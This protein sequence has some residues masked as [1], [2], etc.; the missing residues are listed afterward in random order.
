ML[1]KLCHGESVELSDA[2]AWLNNRPD[3]TRKNF[4]IS[5]DRCLSIRYVHKAF[6]LHGVSFDLKF[7]CAKS[8]SDNVDVDDQA[9]SDPHS[10]GDLF[11]LDPSSGSP[12]YCT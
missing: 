3:I 4:S 1:P 10:A 6:D 8:C 12:M 7:G 2:Y 11:H 5:S 9:D